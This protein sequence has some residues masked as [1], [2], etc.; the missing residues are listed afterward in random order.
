MSNSELLE[1][2]NEADVADQQLPV[3]DDVSSGEPLRSLPT[4]ANEADALE[5]A[6]P[7]D[8]EEDDYPHDYDVNV[9]G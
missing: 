7:A 1:A 4:E 8:G 3:G 9:D 5:Q 6:I 2:V